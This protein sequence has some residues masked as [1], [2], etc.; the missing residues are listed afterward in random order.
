MFLRRLQRDPFPGHL[1][2][3]LPKRYLKISVAAYEN[4]TTEFIS[5]MS[6]I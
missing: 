2:L 1:N 6:R 4:G 5:V 3:P